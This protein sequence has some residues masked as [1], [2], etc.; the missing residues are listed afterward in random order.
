MS[1]F[2][3]ESEKSRFS[4]SFWAEDRRV[5]IGLE[6][7]S[8]VNSRREPEASFEENEDLSSLPYYPIPIEIERTDFLEA[9][10][11]LRILS[12]D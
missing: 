12:L 4:S 9:L 10:F 3:P 8:Y 11:G 1:F 2:V 7:D 5:P 6:E